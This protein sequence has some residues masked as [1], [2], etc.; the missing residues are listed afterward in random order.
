VIGREG[1]AG[2]GIGPDGGEILG[3]LACGI[4]GGVGGEDGAVE[5]FVG[6]FEPR[7]ALVVE[8]GE[9]SFLEAG[10]FGGGGLDGGL[11]D[12]ELRLLLG[13]GWGEYDG[14]WIARELR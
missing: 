6:E 14:S 12:E 13:S 1:L 9:G 7:G 5:L 8:V 11:A 2:T 3:P 10:V 4:G